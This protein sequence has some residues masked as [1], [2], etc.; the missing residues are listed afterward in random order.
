M[1]A[2]LPLNRVKVTEDSRGKQSKN[3][4]F[5]FIQTREG[6]STCFEGLFDR[7]GPNS[8]SSQN[9]YLT[10]ESVDVLVQRGL[11][12]FIGNKNR[13]VLLMASA[14]SSA[15]VAFMLFSSKASQSLILGVL[16]SE[17]T[18]FKPNF[19]AFIRTEARYDVFF[20]HYKS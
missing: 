15:R 11:V 4:H 16:I 18:F 10:W 20:I 8:L 12:Y 2:L 19:F 9:H 7:R 5:L 3:L 13:L 1:L 17:I 6:R 14:S